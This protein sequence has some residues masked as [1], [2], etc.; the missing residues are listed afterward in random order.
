MWNLLLLRDRYNKGFV[1]IAA[2]ASFVLPVQCPK[3]WILDESKLHPFFGIT[4]VIKSLLL[5]VIV[6]YNPI[7]PPSLL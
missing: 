1:V 4:K 3:P 2:S 6:T 5:Q 7:G